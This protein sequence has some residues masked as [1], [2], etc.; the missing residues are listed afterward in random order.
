MPEKKSDLS[1]TERV[2]VTFTRKQIELL[3]EIVVGGNIGSNKPEVIKWIVM[4]YLRQHD[5]LG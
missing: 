3:D 4:E 5:K 2:G 1:K